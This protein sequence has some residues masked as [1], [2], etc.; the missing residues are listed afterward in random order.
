MIVYKE[1]TKTTENFVSQENRRLWQDLQY[2]SM[3]YSRFILSGLRGETKTF[4]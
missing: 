3:P 2:A 4:S 1:L